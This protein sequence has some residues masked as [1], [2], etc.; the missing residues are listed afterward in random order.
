MAKDHR[1]F[2]VS[3]TAS[4]WVCAETKGG[5]VKAL[6]RLITGDA[7]DPL[8][9]LDSSVFVDVEEVRALTGLEHDAHDCVLTS[10]GSRCR[11]CRI[12]MGAGTTAKGYLDELRA[13]PLHREREV[14][15]SP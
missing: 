2:K 13:V 7:K 12:G 3:V 11:F 6:G 9:D 15:P 1:L 10:T 5:A 14:P 8:N 4:A